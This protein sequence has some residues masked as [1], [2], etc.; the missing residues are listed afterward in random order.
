MSGTENTFTD[1]SSI[2]QRPK[3]P[4]TFEGKDIKLQL[5]NPDDQGKKENESALGPVV[6]K[7]IIKVN[8]GTTHND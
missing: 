6:V 7:T 5:F 4:V 8:P 1:E 3:F 2:I